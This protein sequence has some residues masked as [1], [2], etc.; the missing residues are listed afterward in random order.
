MAVSGN[1]AVDMLV[2]VFFSK[3]G[4]FPLKSLHPD[5][6]LVEKVRK[7]LLVVCCILSEIFG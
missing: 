2:I 4:I 7:L 6:V 5:L 1:S 3:R